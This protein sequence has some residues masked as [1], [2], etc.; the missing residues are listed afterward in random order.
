[1][2]F[3]KAVKGVFI[4]VS[5]V[6]SGTTFAQTDNSEIIIHSKLQRMDQSVTIDQVLSNPY[7][8][9]LPFSES[10]IA[11]YKQIEQLKKRNP[12]LSPEELTELVD[13][14]ATEEQQ[15]SKVWS[16]ELNSYNFVSVTYDKWSALNS[17]EKALVVSYPTYA[18]I[19]EGV[20]REVYDVTKAEMGLNGLGDFSDAFRHAILNAYLSKFAS[21]W[22]AYMITTAHENKSSSE[23]NQVAADGNKESDH[24]VM[25]LHNNKEG[26]DSWHWYDTVSGTSN[27]TLINRIENKMYNGDKVSGRLYWLNK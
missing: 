14:Q 17:Y 7:Y 5:L 6:C 15:L 8:R 23:L 27:Q 25:D 18:L 24:Q 13:K 21:E 1:M 2:T 10:A 16:K 3:N 4:A 11:L 20:R 19:S 22:W 9:D 26:R 12:R